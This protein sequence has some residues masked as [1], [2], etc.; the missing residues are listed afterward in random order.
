MKVTRR[1]MRPGESCFGG[2]SGAIVPFRKKPTKS[3]AENSTK[4]QSSPS[5]PKEWIDQIYQ[6]AREQMGYQPEDFKEEQ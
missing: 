2:G 6:E 4:E 1:K 5:V 3:S